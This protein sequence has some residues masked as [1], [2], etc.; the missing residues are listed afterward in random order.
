[1][2]LNFLKSIYIQY[3]QFQE[4]VNIV[5]MYKFFIKLVLVTLMSLVVL[6]PHYYVTPP[7]MGPLLELNKE[8]GI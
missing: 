4:N 8:Y 1:M 5:D 7:Q 3:F 2:S 6:W